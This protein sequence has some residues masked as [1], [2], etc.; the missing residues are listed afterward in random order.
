MIISDML[1]ILSSVI[2]GNNILLKIN[3]YDKLNYRTYIINSKFLFVNYLLCCFTFLALLIKQ[4][5]HKYT[6]SPFGVKRGTLFLF[7]LC[8]ACLNELFLS[9]VI[10]IKFCIVLQS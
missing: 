2:L 1:K 8:V 10:K 5:L 3:K 4:S 7:F 6:F 9:S